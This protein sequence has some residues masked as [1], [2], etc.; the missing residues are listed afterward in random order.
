MK[1]II[2]NVKLF[3]LKKIIKYKQNYGMLISTQLT[4]T[5]KS[6]TYKMRHERNKQMNENKLIY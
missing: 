2:R 3:I 4:N 1:I 5:V 6:N